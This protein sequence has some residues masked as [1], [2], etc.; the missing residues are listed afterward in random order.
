MRQQSREYITI[1]FICGALAIN[2]P[3]LDLFDRSWAPF[4]I[5][6]LYFYLY[7]IW[8][9]LIV[10]LILVVQRS[11]IRDPTESTKSGATRAQGFS[12]PGGASDVQD[13]PES[14]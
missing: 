12:Q 11:E 6:L 14:S 2:Y 7:L 10:L 4:G 3:V 9:V 1:L 5:P 8:F 13:P